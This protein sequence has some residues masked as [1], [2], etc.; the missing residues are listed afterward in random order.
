MKRPILLLLSILISMAAAVAQHN[1]ARH[2]QWLKEMQQAKLEY[3]I[4][5]LGI[6][7]EQ[8]AQFSRTFSDM[9]TEMGTLREN[10][11]SLRRT[12][13]D[14]ANPTDLDYEKAAE[15]QFEQSQREGAIM[16]KYYAKYKTFL[17]KKQLFDYQRVEHRWM[18]KVMESRKKK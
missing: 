12:V 14:K 9:E 15:A 13:R 6:T 16:L 7:A 3:F 5:E 11:G 1:D 17:T 8:K 4:K 10:I 18:K 2:R